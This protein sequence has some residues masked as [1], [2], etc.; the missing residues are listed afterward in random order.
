M[1]RAQLQ[2]LGYTCSVTYEWGSL[3]PLLLTF[4]GLR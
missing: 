1:N 4:L 3:F 2:P